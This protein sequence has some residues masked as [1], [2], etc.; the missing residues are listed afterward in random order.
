MPKMIQKSKWLRRSIQVLNKK[1]D[2]MDENSARKNVILK[3]KEPRNVGNESH[4]QPKKI[5]KGKHSV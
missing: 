3:K 5:H 2:N 4:S 1:I